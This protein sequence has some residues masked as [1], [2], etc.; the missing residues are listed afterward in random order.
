MDRFILYLCS[1]CLQV[2]NVQT[3]QE[4][5][6]Y[7]NTIEVCLKM[8]S[9]SK[10]SLRTKASTAALARRQKRLLQISCTHVEKSQL[11]FVKRKRNL[12]NSIR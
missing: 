12:T 2:I 3:N 4:Y 1:V 10:R 9:I 7:K 11:K 8:L 5:I 6:S